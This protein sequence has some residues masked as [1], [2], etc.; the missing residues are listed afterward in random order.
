MRTGTERRTSAAGEAT[1]A[2]GLRSTT[3]H[4]AP[5]QAGAERQGEQK[6]S[7]GLSLLLAKYWYIIIIRKRRLV[8]RFSLAAEVPPEFLRLK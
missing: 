6:L 7:H 3:D 1:A 5:N 4:A 8:E 2:A